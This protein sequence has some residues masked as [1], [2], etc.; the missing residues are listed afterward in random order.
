MSSTMARACKNCSEAGEPCNET[1]VNMCSR[2]ESNNYKCSFNCEYCDKRRQKCTFAALGDAK[3]IECTRSRKLCVPGAGNAAEK[4]ALRV[5]Q[6]SRT[7][8]SSSGRGGRGGTRGGRGGG[9]PT[10]GR[11]TSDTST[12]NTPSPPASPSSPRRGRGGKTRGPTSGSFS[13][14]YI[15]SLALARS[16]GSRRGSG[17]IPQGA[18][19]GGRAAEHS[20]SSTTSSV[21]N[22]SQ[23]R[24]LSEAPDAEYPAGKRTMSSAPRPT[25]EPY[26]S[27][28]SSLA[29]SCTPVKCNTN[30]EP[31]KSSAPCCC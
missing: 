20:I 29:P 8:T 9:R 21:S 14:A 19:S 12:R 13:A 11:R 25:A 16:S 6:G 30:Q 31:S 2:C 23:K 3:C 26:S 28:H 4:A 17:E 27:F 15:T 5:P 24:K 22:N 1:A 10:P 7:G 18:T